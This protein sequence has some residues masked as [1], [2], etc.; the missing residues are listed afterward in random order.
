MA[1]PLRRATAVSAVLV[2]AAAGAW[3][4]QVPADAKAKAPAASTPAPAVAPSATSAPAPAATPTPTA[5]ATTTATPTD[6]VPPASAT[7]EPTAAPSL[8]STATGSPESS[9][10]LAEPPATSVASGPSLDEQATALL[11]KP[12]LVAPTTVTMS[13]GTSYVN[14]DPARDYVIK[15]KLGTVFPKAVTILGGRNVVFENATMQYAPPVGAPADWIVR[16]LLLQDQRGTVWVSN[17][18]I[19]GPLA[20][21]IDLSQHYGAA[22]VLRNIAID[23]VSGSQETNHADLLQTWA[24]PGKLVVD[25]LTGASSFQGVFLQPDDTWDG[26]LPSLVV[27]RNIDIDVSQ[28]IYALFN[29][30]YGRWPIVATDNIRVK[31]N[32]LRPSRDQW[33][34]PK[35]STGDTS[36]S[37]VVGIGS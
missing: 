30:S 17:L 2:V 13:S 9:A 12:V 28:G 24:G 33:L 6:V 4:S 34:W 11:V 25:G 16:G 8:S 5:T 15:I 26:P 27:L 1:T 36:W 31:Y 32:P 14:L 22:V 35:P 10:T 7:P 20:E 21:G 29:N 19:R 18:Q 23:P 3:I 37:A